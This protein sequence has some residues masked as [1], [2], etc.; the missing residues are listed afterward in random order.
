MAVDLQ[1]DQKDQEKEKVEEEKEEGIRNRVL[2]EV[3]L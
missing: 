1:S 2:L 3:I